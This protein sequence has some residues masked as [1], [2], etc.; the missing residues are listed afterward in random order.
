MKEKSKHRLLWIPTIALAAAVPALIALNLLK[1]SFSSWIMLIA[2]LALVTACAAC[3]LRSGMKLWAKLVLSAMSAVMIV[4][5]LFAA[6]CLPYWSSM[7]LRSD[8]EYSLDYDSVLTF[9]QAK[10]DMAQMRTVVRRCHPA[11]I[12][13]EPARFSEAYY[14]SLERLSNDKEI[15]VND[16]RRE[17]QRALSSIGDGHTNVYPNYDGQR[18]LKSIAGRKAEG[19]KIHSINGRTID[20]LFK[21]R[22]NLFCY[23]AESWGVLSLCDNLNSLSGLDFLGIDPEGVTFTW[24]NEEG[25]F[26][27][28]THTAADFLPMD[29][30]VE[31]NA[32]YSTENL[33]PEQFVYYDY[34][35]ELYSQVILSLTE[36]RYDEVYKE[37]L[38]LMFTDVKENGIKNVIVD[39]RGNGGG[40]SM[41]ANEFIRYL[42]VDTYK[43]GGYYQRLGCFMLDFTKQTTMQNDKYT[44]LTFDGN[45]YLLTDSGS[46]SSAMLFAAYIKDND[47]GTII[48]EHPGN[49]PNGYGDV[50]NFRFH[51]SGLYMSVSTKQF[52]RPDQECTDRWVM[53]DVECDGDE[54]I[55]KL[56]E[57]LAEQSDSGLS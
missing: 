51:N 56:M 32:Q 34:E 5:G 21:T 33:P 25:E 1:V 52:I 17:M 6:Y 36:C 49:D 47:L 43:V 23:E 28:D 38:Q 18:Y 7:N 42:P 22:Y 24:V 10:K 15:T 55:D 8:W 11:F 29:E 37:Y 19:W 2:V 9:E 30:Y 39:L 31:Y 12:D 57:I 41:V 16:L 40:N 53:P 46:F 35:T 54:A 4:I 44:D 26:V 48:G 13:E 14:A 50:A 20:T 27:T 45:V 3:W